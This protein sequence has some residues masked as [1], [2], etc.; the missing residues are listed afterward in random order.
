MS[1]TEEKQLYAF[2]LD[3]YS[4]PSCTSF[5]KLYFGTIADFR[6]VVEGIGEEYGEELRNTFERFVA[7]EQ[8][9]T[10]HVAYSVTRFARFATLIT[11]KPINLDEVSYQYENSYGFYYQVEMSKAEGRVA[12]VK[13]GKQFYIVYW[14]TV[15]NP[16]YMGEFIKKWDTLGDWIWGF[17]GI[18]EVKG[19]TLRNILGMIESA[20]DTEEEAMARF[21]D[22]H[23][24]DFNRFFEDV[25][26]DG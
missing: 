21:E 1:R 8:K 14:L 18:I 11:E 12:V 24:F 20:F 26:G 5:T 13:L 23:D 10:Y 7:G 16:R 19:E 3:D 17:P 15:T 25:F 4:A 22:L 2:E 6:V 9:I